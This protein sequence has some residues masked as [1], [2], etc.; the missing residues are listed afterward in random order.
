[1]TSTTVALEYIVPMPLWASIA[2]GLFI[3]GLIGL[4]IFWGLWKLG[5]YKK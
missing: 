4:I 3:V 5:G 1:M 2:L